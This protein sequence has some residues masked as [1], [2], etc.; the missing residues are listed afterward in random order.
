MSTSKK[1]QVFISYSHSDVDK[2]IK[3]Y[4]DLKTRGVNVWL[5]KK[6]LEPGALWKNAIQKQIPKSRYFLFCLSKSAL[7]K[8]EK[9]DGFLDDELQ[10]AY[11]LAQE[12]NS[13]EFSIVPVRLENVGFGDHRI[14]TMH[15]FDLFEDWDVGI[16]KLAFVLGGH[17]LSVKD[18]RKGKSILNFETDSRDNLELVIDSGTATPAEIGEFLAEISRLNKMLGG[19]GITFLPTDIEEREVV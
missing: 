5:D 4:D 15:Q 14:S 16:D 1:P 19:K 3:L 17:S 12:Q 11:E 18:K 13:R 8:T 10:Q 7:E 2:V 6:D 9:G